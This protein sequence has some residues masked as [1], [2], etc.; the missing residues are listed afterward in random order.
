M[1]KRQESCT[2]CIVPEIWLCGQ[3][4]HSTALFYNLLSADSTKDSVRRR[5]HGS[6]ST[7]SLPEEKKCFAL[8][9]ASANSIRECKLCRPELATKLSVPKFWWTECCKKSNGYF[10]SQDIITGAE[11]SP[12]L[13]T[14]SRFKIKTVQGNQQYEWINLTILTHFLTSDN[15]TMV[16]FDP[17]PAT[18]KQLLES[19]MDSQP[20]GELLDPFWT[21]YRIL[22]DVVRLHDESIWGLTRQ[23]RTIEKSSEDSGRAPNYRK[24]HDLARHVIHI[25]ETTAVTMNTMQRIHA[26]HRQYVEDQKTSERPLGI[27]EV[28]IH[29]R[30]QDQLVFFEQISV[31]LQ[32]RAS[33]TNDRLH[34]EIQ[35]SF[36]TVVQKD[37]AMTLKISRIAQDD[38]K[39]MR[40]IAFLTLIFLP[41][42]FVSA[43]FSTSFFNFNPDANKWTVSDKFWI[44]WVISVPITVLTLVICQ[45]CGLAM[46]GAENKLLR[47]E[48]DLASRMEHHSKERS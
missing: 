11:S 27:S 45:R 28:Q 16:V 30:I 37:S 41:A 44:Y 6:L 24:L 29:K 35:L 23:V 1:E 12:G 33:A 43:V 26:V 3:G 40:M 25:V 17:T 48:T 9:F 8:V 5:F 20:N 46:P 18:R 36:N 7:L 22:N 15:Q 19:L 13:V 39:V 31:G 47:A 10:G 32:K 21:Y 14:W 38:S 2:E 42:T 34:N 4:K